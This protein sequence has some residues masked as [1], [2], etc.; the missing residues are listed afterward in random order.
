M[1]HVF[2]PAF[3]IFER[4][5]YTLE[6]NM[7]LAEVVHG[8]ILDAISFARVLLKATNGCQSLRAKFNVIDDVMPL[9]RTQQI[10]MS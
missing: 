3:D 10:T 7:C 8:I 2:C 4:D 1:L 5:S 9:R 6:Q